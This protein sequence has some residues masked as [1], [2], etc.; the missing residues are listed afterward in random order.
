[1]TSITL[2]IITGVFLVARF[3]FRIFV[4][5]SI[6]ADDWAALVAVVVGTPSS[7][8]N[9][10]G[11]ANN[12]L[13]RDV[14]TLP[15]AEIYRFIRYFYVIE[16]LYFVDLSV[17]KLTLLFFYLRIFPSQGVRRII[18]ATIGFVVVYGLTFALLGIFQ[19]TP[20]SYYWTS[21]DGE[22]QGHCLN[23]NAIG[24]ANAAISIA[25]D[26]WML[27]IPLWQLRGLRMHWKKKLGV[28]VMFTV[29][30]FVTVVSILRLRSLLNFANST[31]PT[32]DNYAVINWSTIEINVGVI[33]ACLPSARLI[34]VHFFPRALGSSSMRYYENYYNGGGPAGGSQIQTGSRLGTSS[35]S[36]GGDDALGG[37]RAR[38]G[39]PL[40]PTSRLE[41]GTNTTIT[42]IN[43][44]DDE[45]DIRMP[46]AVA[47][48]GGGGGR[49]GRRNST[50]G[51]GKGRATAGHH[52]HG[53]SLGGAG[54][55]IMYS[56]SYAVEYGSD[57]HDEA[58]LVY[59]RGLAGSGSKSDLKSSTASESSL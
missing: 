7:A 57:Y 18:W 50:A 42:T 27:A 4:S 13:G 25:L 47:G 12:G 22:H 53:E 10:Q 21:W 40:V 20:I 31:N 1:M 52:T 28:A 34:L 29:G 54:G 30:T 2:G 48:S 33:C 24:W 14:W 3:L 39:I 36:R 41:K 45:D 32:W 6:A 8:M 56:K 15:P 23:I 46:E 58:R 17:L 5:R 37:S 51:V 44:R 9:I 55:G 26:F 49:F 35:V 16:V 11:L 38:R 59:E 19:C 43:A